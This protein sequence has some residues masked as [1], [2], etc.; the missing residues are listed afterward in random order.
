MWHWGSIV[1]TQA[2]L[3]TSGSTGGEVTERRKKTSKW[4]KIQSVDSSLEPRLD[5]YVCPVVFLKQKSS[6]IS[7][8]Q[9][10]DAIKKINISHKLPS[11]DTN[12]R[13][14]LAH[15]THTHT[16]AHLLILAEKKQDFA[17]KRMLVEEL[18]DNCGMWHCLAEAV[19]PHVSPAL[20]GC[21]LCLA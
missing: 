4:R 10:L 20:R 21:S 9:D 5:F 18:A 13:Q 2:A 7:P 14:K 11:C 1:F 6:K 8:E 19:T 3:G 12:W 16:H 15:V 17:A